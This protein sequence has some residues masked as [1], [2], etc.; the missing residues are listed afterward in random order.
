M[1]CNTLGVKWENIKLYSNNLPDN[2]FPDIPDRP[3]ARLDMYPETDAYPS[4]IDYCSYVCTDSLYP[5]IGAYLP[6]SCIEVFVDSVFFGLYSEPDPIPPSEVISIKV[7]PYNTNEDYFNGN[8]GPPWDINIINYNVKEVKLY[9]NPTTETIQLTNLPDKS[10]D[11]NI[12][13][14]QGKEILTEKS[15]SKTE[16]QINISELEKGIYILKI[17]NSYQAHIFIEKI[18]KY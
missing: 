16:M 9:P 13:N 11:I 5:D 7:N 14:I 15:L 6:P 10:L 4:C 8:Y 12:Y 17:I 2:I 3:R 18:I 1:F